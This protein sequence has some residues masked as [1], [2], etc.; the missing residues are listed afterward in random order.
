MLGSMQAQETA[1]AYRNLREVTSDAEN[2]NFDIDIHP[3]GESI[4]CASDRT[5]PY[6][7]ILSQSFKGSAYTQKTFRE[8]TD[9]HFPF[10][11]TAAAL[12]SPST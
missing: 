5:D 12:H 10:L 2:W 8:G 1:S 4:L 7:D 6:G 9:R 3:D 11:R